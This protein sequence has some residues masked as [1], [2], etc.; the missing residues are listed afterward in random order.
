MTAV[1]LTLWWPDR[2]RPPQASA[3]GA[4]LAV[5]ACF[6][7]VGLPVLV[8][9]LLVLAVRRAGWRGLAALAAAA[10]PPPARDLAPGAHPHPRVA[11]RH[12]HRV[13]PLARAPRVAHPAVHPA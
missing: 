4:L 3:A 6:W 9:F 5:S 2:R 1:T 12:R 10:A 8:V 13:P 11:L 7:P